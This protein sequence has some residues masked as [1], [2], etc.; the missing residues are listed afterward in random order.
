[1]DLLDA[2]LGVKFRT[3]FQNHNG[4]F[5]LSI[6]NVGITGIHQQPEQI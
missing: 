3:I 5:L 4:I 6:I 2:K 1:M